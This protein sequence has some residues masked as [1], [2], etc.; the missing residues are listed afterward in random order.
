MVIN[1]TKIIEAHFANTSSV[2]P[3]KADIPLR[4]G[5]IVEIT[6]KGDPDHS[7]SGLSAKETEFFRKV[8]NCS[9]Q[10]TDRKLNVSMHQ[11]TYHPLTYVDTEAGKL[12]VLS[13]DPDL[14]LST[15]TPNAAFGYSK[16]TV[17]RDGV[18]YRA[19]G[20]R[21]FLKEGDQVSDEN[22]LSAPRPRVVVPP[23]VS[24]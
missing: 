21:I 10:N 3:A 16:P 18:P 17:T 7:W 20:T 11:L 6:L 4:G 1:L 9:I 2:D 22:P 5:D 13:G 23:G 12:P 14:V 8:L 15:M 19:V 24:H